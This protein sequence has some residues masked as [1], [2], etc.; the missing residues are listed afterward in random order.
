M[1]LCKSCYVL[2]CMIS[3]P[4]HLQIYRPNNSRPISPLRRT[5]TL[6]LLLRRRRLR[7]SAGSSGLS[8]LARAYKCRISVRLT[9]PTRLPDSRPPGRIEAGADGTTAWVTP[10]PELDR[11]L[12]PRKPWGGLGW[13]GAV[14][15]GGR[16]VEA[17]GRGDTGGD[18][19]ELEPELVASGMCTLAMEGVGGPD[20]EGD[21][22]SVTQSLAR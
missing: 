14:W 4:V 3:K 19:V 8:P 7:I 17:P 10:A 12:E 13:W 5:L 20:D 2:L 18:W 22:G 1:Q 11:K 15:L 6:E 16:T 21:R 9:T